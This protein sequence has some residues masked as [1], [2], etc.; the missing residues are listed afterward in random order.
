[1]KFALASTAI[2]GN[3][4]GEEVISDKSSKAAGQVFQPD[5][6]HKSSHV[7]GRRLETTTL[8]TG[9]K[10]AGASDMPS[11]SVGGRKLAGG[12]DSRPPPLTK[13]RMAA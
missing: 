6:P 5:R 9:L 1:M 2:R 12:F 8:V 4:T 10:A 3:V 11:K 13:V 7:R